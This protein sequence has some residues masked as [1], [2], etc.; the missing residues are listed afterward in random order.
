MGYKTNVLR[1]IRWK[2]LEV[3]D[4]SVT[5]EKYANLERDKG[6]LRRGEDLTFCFGL[7]SPASFHITAPYRLNSCSF[8]SMEF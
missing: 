2:T 3:L 4:T 6:N 7:H 8:F 1:E 5:H